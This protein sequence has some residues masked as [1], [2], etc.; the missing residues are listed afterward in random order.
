VSGEPHLVLITGACGGVGR[1]LVRRVL[2]QTPWRVLGMDKRNWVL[3]KPQRFRFQRADLRRGGAEDVFRVEKPWAVV[4]LAFAGDLR[5]AKEKRHEVNVLGTQRVLE[6]CARYGTRRVVVLSRA[7]VYGARPDNPSLI[8]EEMPLKLGATYTEM[9]DLVEYDQLCRSWMWEHRDV[10]MAILRPVYIVGPNI[11]EG[12][13]H[14]FLLRDPVPSALGFDPMLQ[15]VHEDDVIRAILLVLQ[16]DGRGI[17]NITGPGAL[18]L[19]AL[20]RAMGRRRIPVPHPL[21]SL[22]DRVAFAARISEFPPNALD[23]L[24]FSCI[25]DG[26]K[27]KAELGYEAAHDLKQTIAAIP[28]TASIAE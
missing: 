28:R 4:H 13:L 12:M 9:S 6:W 25:V 5:T 18:P 23:F 1:V 22:V 2:E 7:A 20:L 3:D 16:K 10:E 19:S 15:I 14:D 27:A 17:Y 24:R 11:R 8:T 26:V 21:L